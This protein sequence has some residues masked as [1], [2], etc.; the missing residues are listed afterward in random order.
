MKNN[1]YQL[2]C[3]LL[4]QIYPNTDMLIIKPS[5]FTYIPNDKIQD[6]MKNGI[7]APNGQ[8]KV[9]FTRIPEHSEYY[10][11]F[12][13]QNSPIKIMISK[14]KRLKDQMI[15]IN[16]IGIDGYDKSLTEDDIKEIC[17]NGKFFGDKF[18]HGVELDDMP[19]A[20][21]SVQSG[22]IP[23]FCLKAFTPEKRLIL[24][25]VL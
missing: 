13:S 6:V 12:I 11:D 1:K 7:S 2:I 8:L 9:F 10:Q 24:G 16:P 5:L 22:T 23:A 21:I 25:D 18:S 14:L 3:E 19:H 4:N 20:I 17:E 15:K